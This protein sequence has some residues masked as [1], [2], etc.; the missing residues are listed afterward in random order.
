MSRTL[1]HEISQINGKT[2]MKTYKKRYSLIGLSVLTALY[3]CGGG[4]DDN[5]TPPEQEN[6]AAPVH[7]GDIVLTVHEKDDFQFI[8]LLGT[9][10]G[11]SSGA[12]V[13]TDADGNYMTVTDLSISV[14]GPRADEIMEAGIEQ[15][16]NKLGIRPSAV[17]PNLD[18]GETHIA[19]VSFNISDGKNKTPRTATITFEGEDFA[20]VIANDLS[21]N[22]TKD[23]GLGVINGLSDVTDAD[24]EPLTIS[25]LVADSSNEFDLPVTINGTNF[26]VDIS[27]VED[28]IP[29]GQKVTFKY[30]Y[31]VS[32]HRFD[33]E[34]VLFVNVL[35]VQDIEGAPLVLN[36]F[37]T[38]DILETDGLL[39]VD[40]AKEIEEREGDAIVIS[41]VKLDGVAYENSFEGRVEENVLHFNP[42]AFLD[43]I[44][45]GGFKDFVFTMKVSDDKGN[46]SDGERELAIRVNGVESNL[47]AK[48]GMDVGFEN[49]GT[50]F[51]ATWCDP[52]TQFNTTIVAN[53]VASFQMLGAPCYYAVTSA[54]FPD[55]EVGAKYYF[56]YN[57]Y[58]GAGEASPYIVISNDPNG[59]HN[60]W[61]GVRPEHPADGSWRPLLV[62]FDTESGY[63]ATP[64]GDG[65]TPM[66]IADQLRLFVMS[67]W[68][69]NDG[70]P[71]F[72]D[73]NFTRYDDIAGVDILLDSPGSFES[74]DYEVNSSGGGL[75]EVRV[76]ESNPD[77]HVLYVDTSDAADGV[78]LSFP[79]AK[80]ALTSGAK[81]RISY[82]VQYLNYTENQSSGA[83]ANINDA[84]G[85]TFDFVFENSDSD[86]TFSK[87]STVWNGPEYGTVE[88]IADEASHYQGF[89]TATNW[90]SENLMMNVMIRGENAQY[91]IDNLKVVRIP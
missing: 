78:T 39:E 14:S 18:T 15:N 9:P 23:A 82:D 40:L 83:D 71:V 29:D 24:N 64:N 19:V 10:T 2:V 44:E 26:E 33:L 5:Y 20:P 91:I 81:Y 55:L 4:S 73:F 31:T 85:Y 42:N 53:G 67:A 63:L 27:S 11:T 74:V 80:G 56:S 62:E 34:R 45:P 17:A 3:G 37:L 50:G 30:T 89:G 90:D 46:V 12:G 72:D 35:G 58:V 66:D 47:L 61:G 68:L 41:E 87:S 76:D 13:A 7:G 22:F 25:N 54:S 79:I 60:F 32:D 28:R 77:N 1:P 21:A 38:E 57:A 69:G 49:G 52:G 84:G 65:E 36:Y 48:N 8:E 43:E 51:E 59:A 16:G 86:L 6:T 70:M 75:V 88:S